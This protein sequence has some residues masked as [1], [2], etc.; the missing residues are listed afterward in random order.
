VRIRLALHFDLRRPQGADA[1]TALEGLLDRAVAAEALGFDVVRVAERPAAP[2]SLLPAA[3]PVCAAL[4]ARTRRVR[5]GTAVL[6]LPLHQPLRVAEDAASLDVLS[7]GRFELGVG[8]GADPAA[9]TR[10]GVAGAPR[11]ERLEEA[12]AVIRRAWADGPLDHAGSHFAI[13]GIEVWPKPQQRP[14]PPIWIGAGAAPAQQRAAR[15]GDGLLLAPG[16][17]PAHFLAAWRRAG[18]PL[19]EARLALPLEA[20]SGPAARLR[21]E[22]E[23][24]LVAC[25]GAGGVD[26]V[27]AAE[28]A[29]LERAG[30]ALGP[31]R[32]TSRPA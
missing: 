3:L 8:L 4:A 16:A 29:D 31:L 25:E 26:L 5:I 28:S 14:G 24:R 15:L 20:S 2:D 11:A 30:G 10:F 7:D 6:P 9:A 27:L 22:A 12:L 13:D 1:A 32:G 23:R 19:G 17:D 21:E 18:R